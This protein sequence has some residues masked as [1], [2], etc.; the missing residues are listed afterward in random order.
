MFTDPLHLEISQRLLLALVYGGLMVINFALWKN[1]IFGN[2]GTSLRDNTNPSLTFLTSGGKAIDW[3]PDIP[4]FEAT[5][6]L[7]L[8]GGAVYY[9]ATGQGR[10]VD[11]TEADLVTGEAVI[12]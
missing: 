4:F 1:P 8:I 5:V 11:V 2:F 6:A 3:L 9:I 10:K 7:I 12:A